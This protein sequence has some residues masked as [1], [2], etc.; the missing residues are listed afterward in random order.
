MHTVKKRVIIVSFLLLITLLVVTLICLDNAAKKKSQQNQ[1]VE[2]KEGLK[3]NEDAMNADSPEAFFFSYYGGEAQLA[4]EEDGLFYVCGHDR[5]HNFRI[6][7]TF[8]DENAWVID[9]EIRYSSSLLPHFTIL[10]TEDHRRYF[11][12]YF[13]FTSWKHQK[14]IVMVM[15]SGFYE[16]KAILETPPHDSLNSVFYCFQDNFMDEKLDC[17][18]YSIHDTHVSSY[19]VY[20][21]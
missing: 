20:Y 3:G 11:A 15:K 16:D 18:F 2:E 21:E 14:D 7:V 4:I 10:P 19:E 17:F 9:E 12:A 13:I 5:D 1:A 8:K 6:L